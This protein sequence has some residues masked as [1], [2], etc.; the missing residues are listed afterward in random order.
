MKK[1]I[2]IGIFLALTYKIQAQNQTNNWLFSLVSMTFNLGIP[3]PNGN[4][5]LPFV[6]STSISDTNGNLL[7]STNGGNIWN[8]HNQIMQNGQGLLGDASP[9]Q[10]VVIVPKPGNNDFYYVFTVGGYTVLKGLYYSIVKMSDNNGDGAVIEKNTLISSAIW[11]RQKVTAVKHVNNVDW[12]II[13]KL[14]HPINPQMYACYLL[15]KDGISDL[16]VLSPAPELL[17]V[18]GNSGDLKVSQNKKIIVSADRLEN[19]PMS[20][21]LSICNFNAETGQIFHQFSIKEFYNNINWYGITGVE[22]SPDS[23]LLYVTFHDGAQTIDMGNYLYQYDLTKT[24]S[25]EFLNSHIQIGNLNYTDNLQLGPDGKI[26][27]SVNNPDINDNRFLDVINNVWERGQQCNYTQNQVNLGT[28]QLAYTNLPF[29]PSEFLHRFDF[30]GRCSNLPFT[31]RHRF[32]PEPDSIVWNFGDGTTSTDLNPTHVFQSGGNYEVHAHVVYPD[33]RIEETSRE[34]EVLAAPEPWLGNDTLMCEAS[35]LELD[36][37]TGYT[38]YSWNGQA[39][40]PGGQYYTVSDSGYYYV[41]VRNDL[42]CYGSDT[43]HVGL[44]PPVFFNDSGLVI[45]PTT[46][47]N[48]TGA[49]RG[50]QVAQQASVEWRDSNGNLIDTT[51]DID[52]L[53]V[54][55]YFLTITDTT[56]CITQTPAF[57]VNNINSNL[58]IENVDVGDASCSHANGRIEISTTVLS[59]LLDYSLDDGDT[60]YNNNGIFLNVPPGTYYVRVK[61][62]EGCEAVFTGNPVN[63]MDTGGPDVIG[64]DSIPATGNNADGTITVIATGDSLSYLLNG[65]TLQ[66][67]GYFTGLVSG[68]YTI[69][70]TDKYGCDTTVYITIG[71]QSGLSLTATTGSDRKCL[72]QIA[73]SPVTVSNLYGVKDFIATIVFND[74][75]ITC[76][77]LIEKALPDMTGTVYP[78]KVVLEWHGSEVLTITDTLVL[79]KLLFETNQAGTADLQ[80]EADTVSTIFTDINGNVISAQLIDSEIE[81]SNPPTVMTSGD[82]EQC[83]NSLMMISAFT[84]NGIEP[85]T[86]QW[87][88]PNNQTESTSSFIIFS[89]KP[90]DKGDYIVKVTDAYNCIIED[91]LNITVA[92][93][94][95]AGFSSDTIS[96][97]DQY[98]LQATPGYANYQ[99]NT[100]DTTNYIDV[101]TEGKYSVLIK[102][103]QGCADTSSVVMK[104]RSVIDLKVP[105]AFTPNGDSLNDIF[106]PVVNADL[107]ETFSLVIYNQWGQKIFESYDPVSGWNGSDTSAGV[108]GWVITISDLDGNVI[109]AMGSVVLLR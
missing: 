33:G 98:R 92:P 20:G 3:V 54:G 56:G 49:I 85:Y 36:A 64:K 95:D 2:V 76:T 39:L 94:P 102:T 68:D 24:D 71:Q 48:N 42:N 103:E 23:K 22:I 70:I 106:R 40:P 69:L 15:T 96:F 81:V 5:P 89:L 73:T 90:S 13:T 82:M 16:P 104:K 12:W 26:Y 44:Y 66:D 78:G 108:Y 101:T 62:R 14:Y 55:N 52:S 65:I 10:P 60:W 30:N 7:F 91:T 58:I 38:N 8:K 77:N 9:K 97:I 84:F 21:R 105:N 28:T 45:S 32:I 35:T 87:T 6:R 47:G 72:K 59:D 93:I 83:E 29:F 46:C 31:F 86:Y 67:T 11:A 63:V 79:G 37:G 17:N 43:I 50:I 57:T 100:G 4:T 34:V 51:I 61:D 27:A 1:F 80:W 88:K 18:S 107:I 109:K 99:W 74:Q 53:A 25:L 19:T 41:R 75:K